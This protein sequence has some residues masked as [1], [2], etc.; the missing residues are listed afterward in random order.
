M[1]KLVFI[2]FSSI[3]LAIVFIMGA[4]YVN[5]ARAGA[6]GA[7][8][9]T[10]GP[11]S[12]V[13]LNDRYLGQ[14]PL[15]KCE[16]ADMLPTGSYTIR[17]VP[18]G[19]GFLEF[20]EKVTI[21]DSVLTVVDRKFGKNST[22]EGSIISLTPLGDKKKMELL[23]VSFPQG[24]TALLDGNSIGSTPVLMKDPTESDHI[25]KVR[26]D[27]YKEKTVRIRTP[28]GYKLTVASY[29]SVDA[30]AANSYFK[31]SPAPSGTPSPTPTPTEVPKPVNGK[32]AT[33]TPTRAAD[34]VVILE[35]PTGFLRVREDASV[36]SSE[37]GRAIPGDSYPLIDEQN[38]WYEIKLANGQVGWISKQYAQKQ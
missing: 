36:S 26:K 3:L 30:D 14:T 23:V 2:V 22:S 15:C 38:D 24:S 11:D 5:K 18:I 7:L 16:T 1:K 37:I 9:V 34:T 12:K 33:P 32:R 25:L 20:Q 10:S 29:L 13:Y 21:S 8:Q 17:L 6:K 27:G 19:G 31:P 4:V 28:L 35:T